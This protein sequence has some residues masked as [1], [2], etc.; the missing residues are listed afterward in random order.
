MREKGHTAYIDVNNI[1]IGDPWARSIEKN[2]SECDIFVVILTPDSITSSHVENEVLQAQKQNKIIVPCIHEYVNYNEIKWELDKIQ[3]IEFSNEYQLVLNLYP[4][5]K[6]YEKDKKPLDGFSE[7]DSTDVDDGKIRLLFLA[8]NPEGTA[9][10]ELDREFTT[11][12]KTLSDHK[13]R[14]KFELI[15]E[16][17]AS[18][19]KLVS[20][21]YRHAPNIIHFTGNATSECLIFENEHGEIDQVNSDR[22]RE[23]FRIISKKIPVRCVILNACDSVNVAQAIS[24]YVDCAIGISGMISDRAAIMFSSYFY[25]GLANRMSVIEAVE[26]SE[27]K[28]KNVDNKIGDLNESVMPKIYSRSGVDLSKI[29]IL[30]ESQILNDQFSAVE[31]KPSHMPYQKKEQ[32]IDYDPKKIFISYREDESSKHALAEI[33]RELRLEPVLLKSQTNSSGL[34]VKKFEEHAAKVGYA[35][36]LLILD[37]PGS[38]RSETIDSTQYSEKGRQSLNHSAGQNIFFELGY[39]I[40]KLGKNRVCC[41]YKGELEVPSNLDGICC[42]TYEKKIDECYRH[43]IKELSNAGY[44]DIIR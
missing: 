14:E 11:I 27:I 26:Y 2:I 18:F 23:T 4:K 41:L 29:V 10:L 42:L 31:V 17:H 43:I 33:I 34:F 20:H 36:V 6:N 25:E 22:L 38:K 7:P 39:L 13:V 19:S 15:K 3:G 5:I 28:L 40:G 44:L 32:K 9:P 21:I 24:E 30:E 35:F 12:D 8:A 1:T 37:K 16:A